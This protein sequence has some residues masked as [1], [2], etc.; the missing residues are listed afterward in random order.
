M[1]NIPS[2][3]R[4]AL[5]GDR[6]DA[7]QAHPR[8]PA[9]LGAL[10][11]P[12]AEPIEPYWVPTAA[13]E[14]PADVAGFDG[15]WVVPGSPY[16]SMDGVLTAIRTAR[17]EGIPLLGSCG[18]F[19]HILLEFARHVCGL[20]GVAHAEIDPG[21]E[22][23]LL[24]PLA[25]K[26]LGEEAEVVIAPGTLAAA[27]MGAGPSTERYF[28]RF[29]LERSYEDVLAAAGL[30]ISGRDADGDARVVEL[31]GHPYFVGT[32]FQPEL[33]SDATWVHPLIGAFGRA[34]RDHSELTAVAS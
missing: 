14:S 29:G 4:L 33:S 16:E 30:V 26:L 18:G 9:I 10:S 27:A 17:L 15:I 1:T 5:V 2:P 31:P 7:V 19:Q 28:C 13:I 25:C 24:V 12:G 34:V 6:S 21:A 32:L 22:E 8:I 3:P 11:G 20:P 23:L